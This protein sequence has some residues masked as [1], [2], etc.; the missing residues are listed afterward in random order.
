[1]HFAISGGRWESD[2][3]WIQDHDGVDGNRGHLRTY[4]PHVTIAAVSKA[5][6][7]RRQFDASARALG[8]GAP[9]INLVPVVNG[10]M[11]CLSAHCEQWRSENPLP[12]PDDRAHGTRTDLIALAM[13]LRRAS[14][15]RRLGR[16]R[17]VGVAWQ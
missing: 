1:M 17:L 2:G 10:Y 11:K 9:R 14:A 6:K 7:P 12:E 15:G 13:E 3:I 5:L 4:D 8:G 16:L